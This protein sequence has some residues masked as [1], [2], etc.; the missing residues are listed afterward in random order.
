GST[1]DTKQ[2]EQ[3]IAF[4]TLVLMTFD[5]ER[6]DCVFKTLNKFKGT[7]SSLNSTVRHQ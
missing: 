4:V 5:A 3:I 1:E 6:S 7:V 2:I